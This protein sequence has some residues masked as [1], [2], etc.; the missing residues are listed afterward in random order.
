VIEA[1]RSNCMRRSDRLL[2]NDPKSAQLWE[3]RALVIG[4]TLS[5]MGTSAN[6]NPR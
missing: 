4:G 6:S 1:L 2:R 3:R 5:A